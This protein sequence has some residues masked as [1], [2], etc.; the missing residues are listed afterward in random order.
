MG[1]KDF[2]GVFSREFVVGYFAP[3]F[4]GLFLLRLLVDDR[5]LPEAFETSKAATQVLVLGGVA[6]LLA[7]LLSGLNRPIVRLLEGYPIVKSRYAV[8]RAIGDRMAGRWVRRFNDLVAVTEGP[9]SPTRTEAARRLNTEFPARRESILPTALGNALRSFETHPR[10][11]Y[12]LDGIAVWPRVELLMDD[13]ERGVVQDART[14]FNFFVN[15]LVVLLTGGVFA[16]VD[17]LLH[18]DDPG[19]AAAQAA[20]AVMIGAILAI[21]CYRGA[22]HAAVDWGDS[23]RAAFDV[24]RLD[25]YAKMGVQVP[26]SPAEEAVTARAINRC[27]LYAEPIPEQLRSTVATSPNDDQAVRDITPTS[28]E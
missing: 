18:L 4:F 17:R 25:V 23:V 15:G 26:R 14:N 8:V 28:A 13:G 9:E 6:L 24:H 27:L 20:A 12:G 21:G 5:T 7:L 3:V 16:A 11:R 10:R 19:G 22:T 2:A 1:L